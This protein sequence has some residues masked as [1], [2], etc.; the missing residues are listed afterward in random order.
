MADFFIYTGDTTASSDVFATLNQIGA[1]TAISDS[2]A[3]SDSVSMRRSHT[4]VVTESSALA[5]AFSNGTISYTTTLTNYETAKAAEVSAR[6]TYDTSHAYADYNTW[7]LTVA[8]LQAVLQ[9]D[10]NQQ[11]AAS[12]AAGE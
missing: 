9:T 3:I 10:A 2:S 4:I 8:T 12:M 11:A 5:D 6:A 7:L 1:P